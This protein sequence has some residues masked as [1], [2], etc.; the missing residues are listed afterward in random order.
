MRGRPDVTTTSRLGKLE[1]DSRPEAISEIAPLRRS[2]PEP[3]PEN[4]AAISIRSARLSDAGAE[5]DSL[6]DL[7]GRDQQPSPLATSNQSCLARARA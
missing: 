2:L 4:R 1:N 6:G 5:F 7:A 3:G